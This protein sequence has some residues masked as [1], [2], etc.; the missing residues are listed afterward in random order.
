M[1]LISELESAFNDQPESFKTRDKGI[2]RAMP[3]KP[4]ITGY[5]D[6]IS[7]IRRCGKST[8]MCQLATLIEGDISFFTFEDSRVF[9]FDVDDF[10]KLLHC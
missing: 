7:G 10:P 9:G 6:I 1:V 5:I 4:G 2:E 3:D 8:Y